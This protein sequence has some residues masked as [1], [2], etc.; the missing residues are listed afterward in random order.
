MSEQKIQELLERK[1]F[2]DGYKDFEENGIDQLNN[3]SNYYQ[4]YLIHQFTSL[5]QDK[6]FYESKPNFYVLL[7]ISEKFSQIES[8]IGD[9]QNKL[10]LAKLYDFKSLFVLCEKNQT[11]EAINAFEISVN[12]FIDFILDNEIHESSPHDLIKGLINLFK[13]KYFNQLEE[14]IISKLDDCI[15]KLYT[16]NKICYIHL[17]CYESFKDKDKIKRLLSP[18]L[19]N[20]DDI[21][22]KCEMSFFLTLIKN[23]FNFF[24]DKISIANLQELKSKCG[25]NQD[26]YQIIKSIISKLPNT[27]TGLIEFKTELEKDIAECQKHWF[28]HIYKNSIDFG[29]IIKENNCEMTNILGKYQENINTELTEKN[30]P[31]RKFVIYYRN[32]IIRYVQTM[33]FILIL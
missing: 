25:N 2:I 30:L 22:L 29:D 15:S 11:K 13:H 33:I 12:Y 26:L 21:Y 4:I 27:T 6:S 28:N 16:A 24:K 8:L 17:N 3:E 31:L 5:F 14:S 10:M 20:F 19:N 32:L 7:E 18:I 23:Y 1:E 9:I